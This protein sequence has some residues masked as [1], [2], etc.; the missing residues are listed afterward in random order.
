[1]YIDVYGLTIINC[2]DGCRTYGRIREHQKRRGQIDRWSTRD[3]DTNYHYH[4][5]YNDNQ[6][7]LD[8]S[9]VLFPFFPKS[10]FQCVLLKRHNHYPSKKMNSFFL[11][12]YFF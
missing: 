4:Y 5:H 11:F 12:H 10:F 2:L 3:M 6:L 7:D 1:M 9:N 8:G